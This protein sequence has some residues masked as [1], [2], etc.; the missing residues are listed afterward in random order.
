[1]FPPYPRAILR[2]AACGSVSEIVPV[3]D[4]VLVI[5]FVDVL[6]WNNSISSEPSKI[7]TFSTFVVALS[8]KRLPATADDGLELPT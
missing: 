6:I 5:A 2:A 3:T 7:L 8:T 4:I 1:M